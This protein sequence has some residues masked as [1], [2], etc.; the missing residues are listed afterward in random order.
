MAVFKRHERRSTESAAPR[1]PRTRANSNV[2]ALNKHVNESEKFSFKA[3][4][5]AFTEALSEAKAEAKD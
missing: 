3:V 4:H 5:K 1:S 2:A